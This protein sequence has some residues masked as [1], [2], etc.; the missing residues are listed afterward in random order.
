MPSNNT[1]RRISAAIA[2]AGKLREEKRERDSQTVVD[3]VQSS[4]AQRTLAKQRH[5]DHMR[6]RALLKEAMESDGITP[7]LRFRIEQALK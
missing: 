6:H 7:D 4:S 1:D 3:L 2:L 5:A